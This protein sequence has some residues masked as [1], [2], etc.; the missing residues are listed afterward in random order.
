MSRRPTL[1]SSW[2]TLP[3]RL[4]AERQEHNPNY[5]SQSGEGD[6][7]THGLK[8]ANTWRPPGALQSAIVERLARHLDGTLP[9]HNMRVVVGS[10][11]PLTGT[12]LAAP[13]PDPLY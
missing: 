3:F 8:M 9:L 2:Q 7:R 6:R 10:P 11:T 1:A 13:G 5:E 12:P 4:F